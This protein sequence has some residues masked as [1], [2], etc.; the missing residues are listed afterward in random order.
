MADSSISSIPCKMRH[1]G[2]FAVLPRATSHRRQ[3]NFPRRRRNFLRARRR[4]RRPR[5]APTG[6]PR[7]SAVS[8]K[9][10]PGRGRVPGAARGAQNGPQHPADSVSGTFRGRYGV[11]GSLDVSGVR[12]YFHFGHAQRLMSP[13]VELVRQVWL[14]SDQ[15]MAPGT[16]PTGS[17]PP[18]GQVGHGG[19][20]RLPLRRR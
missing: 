18:P 5:T 7:W 11:G 12:Q 16:A 13:V 1:F 6:G 20:P 9:N 3:R 2:P 8:K 17:S 4:P 15:K 10:L 19:T 14:Q